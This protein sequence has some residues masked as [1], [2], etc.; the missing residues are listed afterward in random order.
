VWSLAQHTPEQTSA[1]IERK[2]EAPSNGAKALEGAS[3]AEVAPIASRETLTPQ[4]VAPQAT[5]QPAKKGW[6]QRPF[7]LRD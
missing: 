3:V 4:A 6:W 2:I 5:D 1:P 7:R